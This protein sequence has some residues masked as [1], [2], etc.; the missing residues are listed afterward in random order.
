MLFT[1][2]WQ[3][4]LHQLHFQAWRLAARK[5]ALLNFLLHIYNEKVEAMQ[6]PIS[7]GDDWGWEWNCILNLRPLGHWTCCTT[8]PAV[9]V[10]N[11]CVITVSWCIIYP[12]MPHMHFGCNT[13]LSSQ[14]P[15]RVNI[16]AALTGRCALGISFLS[17]LQQNLMEKF[18]SAKSIFACVFC[19]C[20]SS[21]CSECT[22]C[23]HIYVWMCV[24]RV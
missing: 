21:V 24:L 14:E 19:W 4:H 16:S 6:L 8:P 12:S 18:H 10:C 2:N 9:C 17:S 20:V 7:E 13:A 3:F 15:R 23:V 5:C 11:P 22:A 1:F